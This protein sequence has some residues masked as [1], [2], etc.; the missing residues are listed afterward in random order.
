MGRWR[1]GPA[2]TRRMHV[3][4]PG[5]PKTSNGDGS[6][7][8]SRTDSGTSWRH[9]RLACPAR[10]I[11]AAAYQPRADG[12]DSLWV[13]CRSLTSRHSSYTYCDLQAMFKEYIYVS[14]NVSL[15]PE[16]EKLV[17]AEV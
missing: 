2:S 8:G 1:V 5:S 3:C 9:S 11:Q 15:T 12:V 6:H 7:S 13:K 16:L 14:M 10:R 17:N 4:H